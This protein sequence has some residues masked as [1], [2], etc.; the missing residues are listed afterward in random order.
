MPACSSAELE[1][2]PITLLDEDA[3]I[4]PPEPPTFTPLAKEFSNSLPG[5]YSALDA[6]FAALEAEAAV[7]VAG[8]ILDGLSAVPAHLSSSVNQEALANLVTAEDGYRV[9]RD[10]T[11]ALK[12]N[13][14]SDVQQPKT[15]V[16]LNFLIVDEAGA[17]VAGVLVTLDA[18]FGNGTTRS[19]DGGGFANF[20][21]AADVLV[22]WTATHAGYVPA[23]GTARALIAWNQHVVLHAA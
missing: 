16:P 23:S 6:S 21:I 22:A 13:V 17:P 5:F 1:P 14:P 3:A 8:G 10:R 18:D 4:G 15:I 12:A 19:T 2:G 20:G 11:A 7:D 9:A